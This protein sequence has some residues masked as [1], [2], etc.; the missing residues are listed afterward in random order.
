MIDEEKMD[1]AVEEIP[2]MGEDPLEEKTDEPD[3]SS[4]DGPLE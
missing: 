2:S 3:E 1:E 4:G